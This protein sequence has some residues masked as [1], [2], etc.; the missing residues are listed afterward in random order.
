[1]SV[2]H[3]MEIQQKEKES[4]QE[5]KNF[6]QLIYI[7]LKGKLAGANSIMMEQPSEFS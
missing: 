1:M 4:I 7:T 2:S 3:F 6:K 5:V